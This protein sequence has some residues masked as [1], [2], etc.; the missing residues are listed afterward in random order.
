LKVAARAVLIEAG[1]VGCGVA[2]HLTRMGWR[3]VLVV[4]GGPFF[5]T[6]YPQ[7]ALT[8]P[9]SGHGF[10]FAS[11]VGE[12]L[13]RFSPTMWRRP[14]VLPYS[15]CTALLAFPDDLF[16]EQCKPKSGA[17]HDIQTP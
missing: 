15:T 16:A 14:A 1:I 8:S 9:C 7:V 5:R 4:D 3:D 13:A 10:K 17:H 12:I 2:E 6:V 11:V